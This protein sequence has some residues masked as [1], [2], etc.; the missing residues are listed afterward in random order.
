MAVSQ[1]QLRASAKYQKKAYDRP[2]IRLPKGYLAIIQ[3]YAKKNNETVNNIFKRLIESEIT[4][5]TKTD[6]D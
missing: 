1:A 2:T 5:L 4:E 6:D 3:E